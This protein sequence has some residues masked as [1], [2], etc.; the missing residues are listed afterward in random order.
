MQQLFQTV[1][2]SEIKKIMKT[3][4][5]KTK[6]TVN[7]ITMGCSKN[8]VDSE[9]LKTQIEAGDIEVKH[10]SPDV[11][12]TVIINTCGFIGPAK[13]ESIDVI[14]DAVKAKEDGSIKN[15]F[16]MGCLSERY[17]DELRD[18]IPEVDQYF[19]VN[20]LPE[21]VEQL[22]VD[23]R[24]DLLGE[25]N[26]TTPSHY[27]YLKISEGCNRKCSFCAIPLIRGKHVSRPIEE[28]VKETEYLVSRG[29][30]EI[31][32]IAQDLSFYGYDLY[33]E[34]R[35]AD[36]I[37]KLSEI[38]KLEWIRLHYAYPANFPEGI[39]EVIKQNPKVCKY[40][41]I[42]IQHVSDKMLNIMRRGHSSEATKALINKLRNEIPDIVIRTTLL[43]GHPGETK[44][45]F[46]ELKEFVKETQFERL[47]V[48]PY[49]EEE[50]TWSAINYKDEISE[51]E[52]ENRAEQIMSIQQNISAEKNYKFI[53]KKLKVIIDRYENEYYIGRS[54]YDSPEVDN[55]VLIY[56]KDGDL[57][58]GNFYWVNITEAHDYDLIG[59]LN[60]K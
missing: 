4:T 56:K 46:E 33:K 43:V 28:L 54:E 20:S 42:P 47:G 34:Y 14:L 25:R 31:I 53:G 5:D 37:T 40:I 9:R 19:G 29:V 35:L 59:T 1:D 11:E 45:D 10:D 24:T 58:V 15:L 18:E 3:K 17:A 12:E 22:N 57:V 51:K 2:L 41:D 38:E 7:I 26:I 16:V 44:S 36:L 27:A 21:I 52:K 13:Q 23:Y 6:R 48:F 55:E 8:L 60:E 49:S 32:L 30:K 39:I 50:D